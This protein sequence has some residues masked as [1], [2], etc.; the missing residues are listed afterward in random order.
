MKETNINA[1]YNAFDVKVLGYVDQLVLFSADYVDSITLSGTVTETKIKGGSSGDTKFTYF[2]DAENAY[3]SNLPLIDLKAL[4][5]KTGTAIND[6][7]IAYLTSEGHKVDA[8]L[9]TIT[10]EQTIASVT[11][12]LLLDAVDGVSTEKSLT[13]GDPGTN[14]DEYSVALQVI[15]FHDDLKGRLVDAVFNATGVA[16]DQEIKINSANLPGMVTIIG[17][18]TREDMNGVKKLV[19]FTVYK[20]KPSPAFEMVFAQGA[21]VNTP[22]DGTVFAEPK[23]DGASIQ[24]IE[25]AKLA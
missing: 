8:T 13:A 12:V 21:A 17:K 20:M 24:Y 10:I 5:V 25:L 16:G 22:F 6:A 23:Q 2:T 4:A 1:I 9:G 11:E 18:G 19:A 14:V 3:A 7:A 15:T